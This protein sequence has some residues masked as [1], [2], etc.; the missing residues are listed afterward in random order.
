[1]FRGIFVGLL[2]VLLIAVRV[3]DGVIEENAAGILLGKERWYL[4]LDGITDIR[5]LYRGTWTI[6][7]FN[8][9]MIRFRRRPSTR[10]RWQTLEPALHAAVLPKASAPSSSAAGGSRSC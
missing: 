9:C 8:G 6:Q 5:I 10:N 3:M 4:F 1:M 2:D 7:H